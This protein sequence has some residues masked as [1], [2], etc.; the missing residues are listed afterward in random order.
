MLYAEANTVINRPV[1]EVF[2]FVLEA[3]NNKFWRPT[4]VGVRRVPSGAVDIGTTFIQEIR[5]SENMKINADFEIFECIRDKMISF[6]ILTGPY[7]PIGKYTFK[8]T[9][10][11]TKVT[12][13]MTEEGEADTK[14]QAHL[15][16]VVNSIIGLKEYLELRNK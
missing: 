9:K 1:S 8:S 2:Q 7:L 11:G 12:F 10:S 6:K 16:S 14:R 15:N 3:E 5:V 4:V 13:V